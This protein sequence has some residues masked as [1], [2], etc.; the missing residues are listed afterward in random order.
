MEKEL[1]SLL[2]GLSTADQIRHY[3]EGGFN[4]FVAGV[5]SAL[6]GN[7]YQKGAQA[8]KAQD[9]NKQAEKDNQAQAKKDDDLLS[10]FYT[11][12]SKQWTDDKNPST[13]QGFAEELGLNAKQAAYGPDDIKAAF[14]KLSPDK[15][16][17]FA[18]KHGQNSFAFAGMKCDANALVSAISS[19]SEQAN[20]NANANDNTNNAQNGD[21]AA[22]NNGGGAAANIGDKKGDPN[23]EFILQV[24]N[25]HLQEQPQAAGGANEKQ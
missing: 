6:S 5:K 13:K 1:Q 4:Q 18:K 2:E 19:K 8:Q 15:Q 12:L 20:A 11:A 23:W 24:L 16:S 25:K 14:E 9:V 22:N 3:E 7:G 21:A 17:A 10:S